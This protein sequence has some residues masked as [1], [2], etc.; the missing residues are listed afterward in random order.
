[1]VLKRAKN[2]FKVITGRSKHPLRES[3]E[4]TLLELLRVMDLLR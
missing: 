4:L 1:M 2:E 3:T